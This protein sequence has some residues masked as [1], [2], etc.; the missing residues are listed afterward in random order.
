MTCAQAMNF[1]GMKSRSEVENHFKE[2]QLKESNTRDSS[3]HHKGLN[4]N[5]RNVIASVEKLWN[6]YTW[7]NCYVFC[8]RNSLGL[9]QP[10]LIKAL[11][12]QVQSAEARAP[13]LASTK[14][15]ER[16]WNRGYYNP[17][18]AS[19]F[20]II[21]CTVTPMT[22]FS[23]NSYNC[24]PEQSIHNS[25]WRKERQYHALRSI[26]QIKPHLSI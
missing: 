2:N 8:Q 13:V 6:L 19:D 16:P 17:I 21:L 9:N 18:T 7:S 15:K 23:L 3:G 10:A 4:C 12:S 1:T 11:M 20:T 22:V 14:D 5:E 24:G 25:I 26:S